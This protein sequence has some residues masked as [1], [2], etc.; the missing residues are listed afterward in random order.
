MQLSPS[1]KKLFKTLTELNGVSGQENEIAHYLKD[2]YGK[3]GYPIVTDN[4]GSIFAFK[5]SNLKNAPKVM[6]VGHM[7]EVGFIVLSIE[8]N[9]M[10]K[11]HPI[12]GLN[13][14]TLTAQRVT[15]KTKSGQYLHG[16]IGAIPPHLLTKEESEKPTEI[17]NIL[18]DFGFKSKQEAEE[19]GV[20][21]G[22][23]MV[24]EGAFEE[25]NQG[26][27]LLGKA[28]DDRYGIILGLE[29]LKEL[30]KTDLAIDLYV[31]GSVQEEVGARGAITSSNLIKPDMAIV[32]DCSP[33]RDSS[34]D[35]KEFGKLGAGVLIRYIDGSMIAFPELLEFQKQCAEK[36]HVKYQY[37]DSTG[38][39]DAGTI[40][41]NLDGIITLT[42]CICAR[43]IHTNSIIMDVDDYLAAKKSL[44]YML[45]HIDEDK[46]VEL[47]GE[48]R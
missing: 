6:V 14:Q 46:I 34:G 17:K 35:P 7:D 21:I 22:A 42:H 4:L 10:L 2:A 37:F 38:G 40:H 5:K 30:K 19:A 39:T 8:K 36:T 31:G 24:V 15:L 28:F 43:S 18:F 9:G 47:K 11:G 26:Q 45:K 25:I 33:S 23:M 27:R 32:L 13:P 12:G 44:K 3:L 29:I 20:Y 48:R 16:A 41:K 1:Q